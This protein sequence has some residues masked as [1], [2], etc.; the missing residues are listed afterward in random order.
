MHKEKKK[1]IKKYITWVIAIFI[2]LMF[3]ITGFLMILTSP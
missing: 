1:K 3:T 2:V